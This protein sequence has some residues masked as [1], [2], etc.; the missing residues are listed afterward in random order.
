MATKTGL[1]AVV[2]VALDPAHL[3]RPGGEG[4]GPGL[5][6]VVDALRRLFLPARAQLYPIGR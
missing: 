1:R 3:G 5:R 6:Q 2:Q 4:V